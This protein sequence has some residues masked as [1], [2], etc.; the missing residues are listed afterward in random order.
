MQAKKRPR[1]LL[2]QKK[3][4]LPRKRLS[5]HLQHQHFHPL[6]PLQQQH[7]LLVQQEQKHLPHQ[8]YANVLAQQT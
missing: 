1:N 6:K 7:L 8:Q 4:H 5:Q 3:R 2:L